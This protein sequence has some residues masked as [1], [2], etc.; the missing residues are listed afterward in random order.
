V[1]PNEALP[2]T[3]TEPP[4]KRSGEIAA[5]IDDYIAEH[6]PEIRA[7]LSAMRA[8]IRQHAP[9]AE[10]RISYRIPTFYLGGNLVHFA[11][12][13]RHV[14]FYPGASGIAAFQKALARYKSAKGSVQ[15][16]HTEPLPLAL[17]ADIVRF[18][19]A[20]QTPKR[21]ASGRRRSRP[22]I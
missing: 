9:D 12:F 11:A 16:P 20:E 17:V 1:L 8:T 15:F 19:V 10:E 21:T 2:L 4:M 13:A 7:R 5:T 3:S 6:P 14:G 18:R 22:A